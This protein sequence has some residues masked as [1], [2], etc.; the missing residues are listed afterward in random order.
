MSIDHKKGGYMVTRNA[1]IAAIL[2]LSACSTVK[3]APNMGT[4]GVAYDWTKADECASKSPAFTISNVPADTQSLVF[5]MTD[6]H[7]PSYNHGGGTVPYSGSGTIPAGAFFYKGPCPPNG[8]H[9]YEF[10]VTAVNAA[11]DT[12]LARGKAVRPFPP[13]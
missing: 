2:L 1:A 12:A 9:D 4:L 10:T 8:T 7:V 11:G 6:L 13:K 5:R 3:D